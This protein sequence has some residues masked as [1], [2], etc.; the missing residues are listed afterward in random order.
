MSDN[1]KSS[2]E[3]NTQPKYKNHIVLDPDGWD[4][5]NFEVSWNEPITEEEFVRRL[6]RS[7]CMLRG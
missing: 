2:Q 5:A 4:R 6:Q 1:L 7:T 3:W